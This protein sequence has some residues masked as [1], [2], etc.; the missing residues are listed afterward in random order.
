MLRFSPNGKKIIFSLT[1]KGKS[2]IFLQRLDNNKRIQIT[3]NKY[4]NTSP[5]FS[6]DG[7]KIV[8]SSDR[9][10]KQNLYIKSIEKISSKVERITFG[11]G[12]YA[13]PA[14]SPEGITSLLQSLT[15][16]ISLLLIRPNGKGERLIAEGY[17]TDGQH[18]L[19]TEER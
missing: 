15:E 8:F 16:R 10:G 3:R 2:N 14:W 17:L 19:Q 5:Y 6:P 4:I 13:T 7:K 9:A 12:N 1:N 18:G 11:N